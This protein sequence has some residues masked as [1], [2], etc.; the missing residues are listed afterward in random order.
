MIFIEQNCQ[1]LQARQLKIKTR[2][3]EQH[4][5]AHR[6]GCRRYCAMS[7]AFLCFRFPLKRRWNQKKPSHQLNSSLKKYN[8]LHGLESIQHQQ[9]S[10]AQYFCIILK[11]HKN[12]VGHT[13]HLP[14]V[15]RGIR[16]LLLLLLQT[17]FWFSSSSVFLSVYCMRVPILRN[18]KITNGHRRRVSVGDCSRSHYR[19]SI[20]LLL[21][22]SYYPNF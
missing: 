5:T 21:K 9:L 10:N 18:K 14:C 15:H 20:L 6:R 17:S 13:C 16:L 12:T 3:S 7:S 1:D 22:G 2:W 8:R 19:T 11:L 4:S